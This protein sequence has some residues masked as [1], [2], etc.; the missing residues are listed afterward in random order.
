[1][2]A[3]AAGDMHVT[4]HLPVVA[5]GQSQFVVSNDCCVPCSLHDARR[6]GGIANADRAQHDQRRWRRDKRTRLRCWPAPRRRAVAG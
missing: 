6:G 1:M 5:A 4:P 3:V 2:L